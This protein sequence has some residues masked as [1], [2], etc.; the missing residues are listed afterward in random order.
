M[1]IMLAQIEQALSWFGPLMNAGAATV[2]AGA[3]V[4][5][6]AREPQNEKDRH[7]REMERDQQQD[8]REE[9]RWNWHKGEVHSIT[10]SVDTLRASVEKLAERVAD[11]PCRNHAGLVKP[12][13]KNHPQ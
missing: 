12:G 13:T 8:Q 9:R 4:W 5:M 7:A 11:L 3:F 1:V 6:I 2:M 10:T